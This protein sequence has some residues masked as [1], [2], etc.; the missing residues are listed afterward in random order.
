[1][2]LQITYRPQSLDEVVGNDAT[3]EAV[4]MLFSRKQDFP[5]AMLFS[6]PYGCG[7]TTIARIIAK[8]L[9]SS[10]VSELNMSNMRGIDSVR[11]LDEISQYPPV[12]GKSR[13]YILDE[14]H[15]Q[16]KDAQNALLKLLEDSPSHAFFI[17]CTTDP[18][19]LIPTLVSRCHEFQVR[20][21]KSMEMKK[22][23]RRILKQEGIEGYPDKILDTI[24]KLSEGHPRDAIKML[25]SIIDIE[26]DETAL[27]ALIATYSVVADSKQLA[28]DLLDGVSWKFIHKNLA[29]LLENNDAEKVRQGLHGYMTNV[30]LNNDG[31]KAAKRARD[32]IQL[33]PQEL[34]NPKSSLVAG[35]FTI[36]E[37]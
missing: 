4:R 17:L 14:I 29:A 6:G 19:M 32:V 12:T 23:L 25:D 37:N 9:E 16:T 10:D 36:C 18:Q 24:I 3:V 11:H 34:G 2:P 31:G 13:V 15:R 7:K 26:S 20:V 27:E 21:L 28:R 1:M 35:L 30:L 22:L 33:T 8:L 5:H